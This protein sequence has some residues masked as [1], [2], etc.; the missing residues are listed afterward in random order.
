MASWDA[1]RSYIRDNYKVATDSGD[2]MGLMFNLDGGRHQ[3]VVVSLAGE[4]AG[5]QWAEV[6]TP[7]AKE[8][9]VGHRDLLVRN[10]DMVCGGLALRPGP[11]GENIVVFRHSFPLADL[12]P[13]E[14]EGPLS[15]AVMFGDKLEQELTGG[16]SW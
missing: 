10:S 12:D 1:L 16:D 3:N 7:V 5:S 8:S 9:Q 14:F 15:V 13:S 6:S 11:E 4:V 2:V